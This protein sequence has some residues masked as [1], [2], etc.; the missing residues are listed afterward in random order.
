MPMMNAAR[1][2]APA[3][4]ARETT[5]PS[6]NE[7]YTVAREAN[8][9][10]LEGGHDVCDAHPAASKEGPAHEGRRPA[11]SGGA[12]TTGH[13]AHAST[14]SS[15]S[16]TCGTNPAQNSERETQPADSAESQTHEGLHGPAS[17]GRPTNE[18]RRRLPLRGS[19]AS[20]QSSSGGAKLRPDTALLYSVADIAM[21]AQVSKVFVVRLCLAGQMPRGI[22]VDGSRQWPRRAAIRAVSR[23]RKEARLHRTV[24]KIA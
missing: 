10:P 15:S 5:S 1:G 24:R 20:A 13:A 16:Q 22:D 17:T 9:Q 14:P 12:T 11:V 23:C 18:G 3:T 6:A 21:L 4:Q 8:T 7:S 2:K 19:K